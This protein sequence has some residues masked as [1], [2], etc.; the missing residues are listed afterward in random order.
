[1]GCKNKDNDKDSAL[2]LGFTSL[3]EWFISPDG[4]EAVKDFRHAQV[5]AVVRSKKEIKKHHFI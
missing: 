4:V 2:K 1:M 3:S 5:H